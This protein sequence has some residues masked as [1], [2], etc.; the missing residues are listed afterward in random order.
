MATC[1]CPLPLKSCRQA[2]PGGGQV[3]GCCDRRGKADMSFGSFHPT[4][5]KTRNAP[6]PAWA[7]LLTRVSSTCMH[8][9]PLPGPRSCLWFY[10]RCPSL[11]SLHVYP[12]A[13]SHTHALS[14]TLAGY[15]FIKLRP[16]P[17]FA[18]P[19]AISPL[20]V[21]QFLVPQAEIRKKDPHSS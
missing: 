12:R 6:A 9:R 2:Q 4:L 10:V 21:Q 11:S 15:G 13:L 20:R 5:R 18:V 7:P 17:S 1:L 19:H 3:G 8:A 14:R 16:L